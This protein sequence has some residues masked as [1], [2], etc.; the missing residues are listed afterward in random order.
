MVHYNSP[1][2]LNI[3]I[4]IS[5]TISYYAGIMLNAFND[6]L[7]SKLCWHNRWVPNYNAIA[8]WMVTSYSHTAIYTHVVYGRT[9]PCIV[10]IGSYLDSKC[11]CVCVCVC[12]C[13]DIDRQGLL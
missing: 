13:V 4:N 7:G 10:I 12:M 5:F 1:Q 6:P 2:M 3:A 11:L 8:A 9:Q